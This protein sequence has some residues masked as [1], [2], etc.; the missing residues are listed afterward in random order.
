[1]SHLSARR[2]TRR[3][4][5]A[6][7]VGSASGRGYKPAGW[8]PP[9]RWS[10]PRSLAGSSG[11]PD[12]SGGDS[13]AGWP[14]ASG[15]D[16]PQ[17][18]VSSCSAGDA[19]V[20]SRGRI[21]MTTDPRANAPAMLASGVVLGLILFLV[22]AIYGSFTIIQ[23][24]NVGV[25]FNR[26]SGALKTVGQGV[27]WRVPWV[28]QVQSYPVA[29]RTYTMVQRGAEGSMRGDDSID[30]PT[31]EGQ[32]IRQDISVTYNTSQEKAADVFRS[33]RGADISDIESTFIRRTII[34]VSQNA[35]GQVS[36]TDLI[37]NQRGQ[38]QTRIQDDLQHEMNKMGFVVDKVNLGA[39]HL[40]DVI[41][42]QLQQKMAAQQQAQQADYELQRQQTLAKAKV[43]EAEGEAQSTLVKA[44]AQA[45]ANNLLQQTLS[46]LLIQNKAIE[47]W[48]GTLPQFTGGGAIPF[49][50]LK[51]LGPDSHPAA[52][53]R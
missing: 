53:G 20:P 40:P 30:L 17:L 44:K 43:A 26:W 34:T 28:T 7:T 39:S 23:P 9:R 36:L 22:A 14:G 31:K 27:A 10:W 16:A 45:E 32:H 52:T 29:L 15:A 51:D 37:S 11:S 8:V 24:G 48:N 21:V 33:F 19:T 38:L 49:L 42:K 1:M 5:P 13:S 47:R 4:R 12:R 3:A 46:P 6:C 35:A 41:E 18:G 50:N 25:V 2:C